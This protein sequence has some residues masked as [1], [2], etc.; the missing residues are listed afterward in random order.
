MYIRLTWNH[1]LKSRTAQSGRRLDEY[2]VSE[3]VDQA[4]IESNIGMV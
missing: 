4:E 3:S 2:S 1:I